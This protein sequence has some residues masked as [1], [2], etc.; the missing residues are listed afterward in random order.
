[1][2]EAKGPAELVETPANDPEGRWALIRDAVQFQIKLAIDGLRDVMLMPLSAIGALLNLFG[3]RGTPLDFY[4]IV[5]WGK[6]T[7][8]AI[9]LFGAAENTGPS[10]NISAPPAVDNVLERVESLVVEQ[11]RKGG[12]TASAK[13]AIDKALDGLNVDKQP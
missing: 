9:N 13:D 12:I 1:M 10:G 2:S 6:R 3:V 4:N 5:R 8:A 7:E 11:Y